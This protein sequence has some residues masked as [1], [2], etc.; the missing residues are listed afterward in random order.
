MWSTRGIYAAT[1]NLNDIKIRLEIHETIF[2]YAYRFF[3]S[4]G[5]RLIISIGQLLF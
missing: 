2:I 4:R 3:L 1:I 5:N